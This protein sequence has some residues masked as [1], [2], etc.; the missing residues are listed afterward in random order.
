M[1]PIGDQTGDIRAGMAFGAGQ[2]ADQIDLALS[3]VGLGATAAV[4]V[5][6]GA[7]EGV[8]P[9]A[10]LAKLGRRMGRL[11]RRLRDMDACA[12]LSTGPPRPSAPASG[13][14]VNIR[15]NPAARHLPIW[16][17]EIDAFDWYECGEDDACHSLSPLPGRDIWPK[18]PI[19]PRFRGRFF[20]RQDG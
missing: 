16:C 18:P 13:G 4:L 17:H 10:K 1:T 9:G 3:V 12:P 20:S 11:S 19:P 14:P 7:F 6:I 5:T 15:G 8:R 2:D